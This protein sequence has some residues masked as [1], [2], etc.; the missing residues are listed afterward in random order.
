[1]NAGQKMMAAA[2]ASDEGI[3]EH[4]ADDGHDDPDHDL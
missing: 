3:G 4:S 1:M 2:A